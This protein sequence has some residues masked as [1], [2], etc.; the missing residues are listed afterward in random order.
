MS[1]LRVSGHIDGISFDTI[2]NLS[3]VEKSDLK[4]IVKS[5]A[6]KKSSYWIADDDGKILYMNFETCK[7]AEFDI[8]EVEP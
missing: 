4:D 6:H 8:T 7:V 5:A 2:Y 3:D 1:R